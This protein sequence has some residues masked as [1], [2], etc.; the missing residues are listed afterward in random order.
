MQ[1]A[2]GEAVVNTV[3]LAINGGSKIAEA[4]EGNHRVGGENIA[5]LRERMSQIQIQIDK[6]PRPRAAAVAAAAEGSPEGFS[7]LEA[8]ATGG[9]G[10]VTGGLEALQKR[11][12]DLGA[13]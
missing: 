3:P 13:S 2:D 9:G 12:R 1:A 6:N 11:I 4:A 8:A 5:A 7:P 10:G